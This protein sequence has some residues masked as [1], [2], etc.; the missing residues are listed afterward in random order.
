[1]HEQTIYGNKPN[2]I[3][4]LKINLDYH[5]KEN[6][7]DSNPDHEKMTKMLMEQDKRLIDEYI[8]LQEK[9][10]KWN[11]YQMRLNNGIPAKT[12]VTDTGANIKVTAGVPGKLT[13]EQ[14]Q[15]VVTQ[16]TELAKL[17]GRTG[18]FVDIAKTVEKYLLS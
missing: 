15:W 3:E 5:T 18:D 8:V 2:L 17:D 4:Y 16:A 11:D 14:K 7:R 13:I 10:A 1:M 6:A 9:A 12:M